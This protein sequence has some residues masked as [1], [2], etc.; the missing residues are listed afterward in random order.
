LFYFLYTQSEYFIF[1]LSGTQQKI[2]SEAQRNQ[3][4]IL[5]QGSFAAG[6]LPAGPEAPCSLYKFFL[7]YQP[8][9]PW[10]HH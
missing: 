4:D 9:P 1:F 7:D 2:P 6:P 8:E 5:F 10:D 3:G